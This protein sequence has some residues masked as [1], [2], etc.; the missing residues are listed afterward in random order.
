MIWGWVCAV[1]DA[2]YFFLV[3]KPFPGSSQERRAAEQAKGV[4]DAAGKAAGGDFGSGRV[5]SQGIYAGGRGARQGGSAGGSRPGLL[6][7]DV[8]H[9]DYLNKVSTFVYGQPCLVEYFGTRCPACRRAAPSVASLARRYPQAYVVGVSGD[10]E[11]QIRDMIAGVSAMREYNV[12]RDN[13]DVQREAQRYG[14]RGIP[15]AF[16]YAADGHLVWEGHPESGAERA[17]E[18]AVAEARGSSASWA[19]SGRRL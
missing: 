19:G 7:V 10:S 8:R 13:G 11:D 1:R 9:L 12:A 5:M 4:G 15:H 18:Q 6:P 3:G 17:L 16:V 14:V 2:L